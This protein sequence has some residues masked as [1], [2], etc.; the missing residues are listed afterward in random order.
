MRAKKGFTLVEIMVVVLI[1][2][3]L[4]AV[5]VPQW[6]S[7]RERTRIRACL[8]NLTE[9]DNAKSRWAMENS[10]PGTATPTSADLTTNFIKSQ[11]PVC[12]GGGTYTINNVDTE[13]SCSVHGT[14]STMMP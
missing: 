1:I 12:P 10:L 3:I 9:I 8:R 13:P 4:L 5:A 14:P 2:G 6:V 7:A 11:F